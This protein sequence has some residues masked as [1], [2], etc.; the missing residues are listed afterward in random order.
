MLPAVRSSRALRVAIGSRVDRGGRIGR[1][2]E[3]AHELV[4]MVVEVALHLEALPQREARERL[5][6]LAPEAS[7]EDAGKRTLVALLGPHTARQRFQAHVRRL[8]TGLGTEDD[9]Q[10]LLDISDTIFGK[11]F[12]ALGDGAASPILSSIKY[13]RD[14]YIAHVREGK[15]PLGNKPVHATAGAH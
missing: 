11:S 10:K 3:A 5:D 8:E 9:I 7:G 4:A 15:C 2:S 1:L 6:D 14:E 12:C 13:F